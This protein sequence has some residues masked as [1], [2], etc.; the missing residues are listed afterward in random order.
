M[1]RRVTLFLTSCNR[2]TLLKKTLESFTKFNTYPIEEA[3]I[4][5]D[6]GLQ[7]INDFV[8][9]MVPYP[10]RILY[11]DKRRGQMMSIENGIQ[12]LKT[13]YVFH[14]EED[15]EFYDYGFIEKSFEILDKDPTITTV[16]LRSHHELSSMYQFP[17]EKIPNDSYYIIGPSVG[18]FSF[19]PGLK[20]LAVAKM[21]YPYSASNLLTIC[22]GGLDK[23]FRAIGMRSA[24]TD[25]VNGYVRHIGWG[26]HVY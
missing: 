8:H 19:N 13:S 20:T 11:A 1:D 6:S 16:Q 18:N 9:T 14:C 5:E 7:G 22:E 17:I 24:L 21:F 25:T 4:M 15:W 10:V 26:H 3:I 23:A 2:P 12:Y